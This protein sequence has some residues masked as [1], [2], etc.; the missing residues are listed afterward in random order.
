MAK[1][2]EKELLQTVPFLK[3]FSFSDFTDK[4]LMS[5]GMIG[6]VGN[7]LAQP[8]ISL[9]LGEAI[10]AF[11]R[12]AQSH[13]TVSYVSKVSLKVIYLA[14]GCGAAASLQV[15]CW[16]ITGER[17]ASRIRCLY[18]KAVLRQEIAYFDQEVSAGEVV[19]MMSADTVL[20]HDAIGEKVG[21]L[22]Q[23]LSSLVGGFVVAFVKGWLLTLVM[24]SSVPLLFSWGRIMHFFRARIASRSQKAHSKAANVVQ[25]VIGAI[26]TV[27][28]FTLEKQAVAKYKKFLTTSYKADTTIAFN[29]GLDYGFNT[30]FLFSSHGCGIL[31]G[32]RMILHNGYTG[33][34]VLTILIAVV[35]GSSVLSQATP[36]LAAIATAQAA[37]FKI[38]ETINRSPSID[39]YSSE[40]MSLN[41]IRGEIELRNVSFFYPSRPEEQI[42]DDF[43]L[44]VPSG[45]TAAL[46]GQTGSG[47]STV[48]S[49]IQR[50][51]DPQFGE[52]LIDGINLKK[53]QLKWIRS[54]IGIV[55]QEPMLFTATIIENIAYGK[56]GATS[57]EIIAAAELA[58]LNDFVNKLPEGLQTMVGEHGIQLSGGQKQRVAI[59]R[60][61]LKDPK[62]LL[63]D[64]A[65]SAL[66][67]NTE[68]NVV[69][70]LEEMKVNR[71][72]VVVAH[73][74][75][76]IRNADMIAVF[77]HGRIVEQGKHSELLE[78]P[79]G[80]YSTLVSSQEVLHDV[81]KQTSKYDS[82]ICISSNV[83][84]PDST[85]TKSTA[86]FLD[87]NSIDTQMVSP[88]SINSSEKL[89]EIKEVSIFRIARLNKPEQL[90]LVA[91]TGFAVVSGTIL[92]FFAL[93]MSSVIGAFYESP[94]KLRK[95]SKFGALMLFIIGVIA[96][97]STLLRSFLFGVAGNRLIR[98]IRLKCFEK[99][100]NMEIGWFDKPENSSGA[101]GSRL[102]TDAAM[103]RAL[104]GDNLSQ[105]VQ[106]AA[107]IAVGLAI[108][109]HA[110]W[111][112]SLVA[113]AIIPIIGFNAHIQMKA[114][115]GFSR[116]AKV[117][118]E[119]V[120][121]VANNAVSNIRT[122]ASFCA[123]DRILN[124]F[125]EKCR[126]PI[127]DGIK[128]GVINAAGFGLSMCFLYM[129]HAAIFYAGAMFVQG[130]RTTALDVFRV[131]YAVNMGALALSSSSSFTT[132]SSKAKAAA[133]S[134][135][136]ILESR[137]KIDPSDD[138]G[139]VPTC[140]DGE[141]E[142]KHVFFSYPTRP[143]I[144]VLQDLS[145][146][147]C[148]GEIVAL[149]GE[150][151]SGKS[152]VI[153]LLQRFYDPN[154]GVITMDGVEIQKLQVKWLRQQMGLVSQE[155]ILFNDTIRANI[156]S[157]KGENTTEAEVVAAAKS[158]N[159]H[160]FISTLQ[161]G[162]D[163]IVGER[164]IQLSGGQKQRVAIARALVKNPKILLLDEATS[165]LDAE[166]EKIVQQALD[167][168]MKD[169]TTIVVAHRLSTIKNAN[170]IVVLRNGIVVEKGCHEALM[171]MDGVYSS[172]VRLPHTTTLS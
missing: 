37:A 140:F 62:I 124:V 68:R 47:K 133:A 78:N 91:A 87:S 144:Q 81:V 45:A 110:S 130:R 158:A 117:R 17:Q 146:T 16:M 12:S 148:A 161:Q 121:Q 15:A 82:E 111:E 53:F 34:E 26:R 92:P 24:L 65:T 59:A 70:A 55:S 14:L 108:A 104:V 6:A 85:G 30:L 76:T 154:S 60:A 38:F 1:T 103:I 29:I 172:L 138:S 25:Q 137:S 169:K 115:K 35:A 44:C 99:V 93:V 94:H 132:D 36:C 98:R 3:L 134:V 128:Q 69:K 119:E 164:G 8:L 152:T 95:D 105:L 79:E 97:I 41:E 42:L 48:I 155:P 106:Q 116:N 159:A 19:G 52:V 170:T 102:S 147:I 40:G 21:K 20:I 162:Y 22:I 141:I 31:F 96:L 67:A 168:V 71:T 18:L 149:V 160:E 72:T 64:E 73:R 10:D 61:I 83:D 66:D 90:I 33:G 166:S 120:S 9:L 84:R 7:G 143:D 157:G 156:A 136:A 28:S 109:F 118:Y 122:V 100:V 88:Y 112:L 51:Y 163:T 142:L 75:S 74:L 123:Q 89:Q 125:T 54:K 114:M 167:K 11:G 27:A 32:A 126:R 101:I 49:L 86:S 165:S 153:S 131:Y 139:M 4:V 80:V 135:F 107:S 145:L 57:E 23:V 50:F 113:F 151:G 43:C 129:I 56:E 58:N 127:A 63:F 5:V 39:A 77:H 13:Q 171:G 150:S 2:K 46:V